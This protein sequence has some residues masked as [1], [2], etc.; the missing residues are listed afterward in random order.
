M[1]MSDPEDFLARWSRRKRGGLMNEK[2]AERN[3]GGSAAANG[4]TASRE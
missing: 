1:T 4:S 3:A 2:D